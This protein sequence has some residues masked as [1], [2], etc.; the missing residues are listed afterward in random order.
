MIP[1][2]QT[3]LIRCPQWLAKGQSGASYLADTNS[4]GA[5]LEASY[6]TP[7][8]AEQ[9]FSNSQRLTLYV[10]NFSELT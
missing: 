9:C 10:L 5:C 1:L 8:A 2:L 4:H 3:I 6:D 7:L